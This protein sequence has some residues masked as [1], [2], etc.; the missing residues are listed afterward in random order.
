MIEL[1]L[2]S[3]MVRFEDVVPKVTVIDVTSTKKTAT[4]KEK[5]TEIQ[6]PEKKETVENYELSIDVQKNSLGFT[7]LKD[8]CREQIDFNCT[9]FEWVQIKEYVD[10]GF[11]NISD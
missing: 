6:E 10:Q 8:G 1:I 9:E 7:I 4:T 2:R 11:Q 3:R 5:K